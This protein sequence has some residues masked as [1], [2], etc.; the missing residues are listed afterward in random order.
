MIA[1]SNEDVYARM[2]LLFSPASHNLEK[3]GVMRHVD[4]VVNCLLMRSRKSTVNEWL[5]TS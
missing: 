2:L 5:N 1:F 3:T 4:L